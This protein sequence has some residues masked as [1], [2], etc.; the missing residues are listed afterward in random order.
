[1]ANLRSRPSCFDERQPS[2]VG[3][4]LWVGDDVD[5]IAVAQLGAQRCWCAVDRG[6]HGAVA[7]IAVDR[8]RKIDHRG[9]A[10]QGDDL[11]LGSEHIHRIGKQLNLDV[12]PELAGVA[13]FLLN[14]EQRLQP[15]AA[16][17]LGRFAAGSAG[18]VEPMRGNP[19]LGHHV[20]GLGA[21]LKLDL[22]AHRADQG[23]VQRLVTVDLR[24][25]HIVSEFARHRFV[26]LVQQTQAGVAVGQLRHHHPKA[27]DV[28]DL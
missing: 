12:V 3:L 7:H 9:P 14:V 19:R 22:G 10:W 5:H 20:H 15:L 2:G 25:R 16:Q 11:A 24:Y 23:G 13:G 1:M 8:V 17:A 21:Q 18:F 27:I 28:G 6:T 26:H 4:G